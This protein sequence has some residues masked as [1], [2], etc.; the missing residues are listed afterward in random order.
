M[1]SFEA[2]FATGVGDCV[3]LPVAVDLSVEDGWVHLALG[4]AECLHE[5]TWERQRIPATNQNAQRIRAVSR[6]YPCF[7]RVFDVSNSQQNKDRMEAKLL[8]S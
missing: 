1:C 2:E 3:W 6:V 4:F 5:P 7:R 8:G